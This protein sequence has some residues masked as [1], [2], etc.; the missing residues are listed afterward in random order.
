[1][2][3]IESKSR[4]TLFL[5]RTKRYVEKSSSFIFKLLH[6]TCARKLT[7][8]LGRNCERDT[9]D[10]INHWRIVRLE[11]REKTSRANRLL[12]APMVWITVRNNRTRIIDLSW[13]YLH[14]P[15]LS[16]AAIHQLVKK[17]SYF[18]VR[19]NSYFETAVSYI[20]EK[21]NLA[22]RRIKFSKRKRTLM[23]TQRRTRVH[24]STIVLGLRLKD[25]Y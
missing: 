3:A 20:K 2:G 9:F 16:S 10:L 5:T 18:R 12:L 1:M 14:L 13:R 25:I 21:S 24:L 19:K 7:R 22:P 15:W 17:I 6:R 23:G 4:I 11:R 8:Y